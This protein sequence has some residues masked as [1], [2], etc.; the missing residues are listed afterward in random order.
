MIFYLKCR[1][2][3]LTL[4]QQLSKSNGSLQHAASEKTDESS[5]AA[6]NPLSIQIH[7]DIINEAPRSVQDAPSVSLPLPSVVAPSKDSASSLDSLNN[8]NSNNNISNGIINGFNTVGANN[9]LLAYSKGGGSLRSREILKKCVCFIF[10]KLYF[11]FI[12][13]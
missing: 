8:N 11:D 5:L 2:K 6:P 3:L 12:E 10:Y 13:F 7:S 9:A 4:Q 1:G